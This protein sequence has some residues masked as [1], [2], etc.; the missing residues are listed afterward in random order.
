MNGSSKRNL[1]NNSGTSV[2]FVPGVEGRLFC[3]SSAPVR[4]VSGSSHTVLVVPPFAEELNRS[5][6][7]L[8]LLRNKISSAGSTTTLV[9]LFGTGDSEGEF[10]NA[11]VEIWLDDLIRIAEQYHTADTGTLSLL[12][13]RSGCLLIEKLLQ[14]SAYLQFGEKVNSVVYVQPEISGYDVIQRMLR[15]RVAA[16]RFAGDKSETTEMLWSSLEAGYTVNT[17]GY[18]IGSALALGMRSLLIDP[19]ALPPI[20]SARW[21]SL[22]ESDEIPYINKLW[23]AQQIL[24][25]PFWQL[26]DNEPESHVINSIAKCVLEY[27][28]EPDN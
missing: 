21:L 9:D 27:S 20:K 15:A 12:G 4:T 22:L 19:Q 26:H 1:A 13:V 18:A 8:T 14:D 3:I 28:S 23:H 5:R 7:F 2:E 11:T 17:S 10:A 6:R 25:R 16:K 24:S